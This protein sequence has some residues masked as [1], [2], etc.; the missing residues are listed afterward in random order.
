MVRYGIHL[1][2]RVNAVVN[3]RVNWSIL[4]ILA[5]IDFK[6]LSLK[7]YSKFNEIENVI[8]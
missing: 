1:S 7:H 4:L 2:G 5:K 6:S 3:V 8:I